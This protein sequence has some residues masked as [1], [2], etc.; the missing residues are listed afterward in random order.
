LERERWKGRSGAFVTTELSE[1]QGARSS[2]VRN[3]YKK[4][5]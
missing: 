4:L 2:E 3:E 1:E 5:L